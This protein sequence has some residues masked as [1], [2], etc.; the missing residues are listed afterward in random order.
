MN[1]EIFFKTLAELYAKQ[2]KVKL[3]SITVHK[4]E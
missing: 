4:K 3:S 1:A 2:N